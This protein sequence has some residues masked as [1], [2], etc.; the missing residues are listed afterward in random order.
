VLS[1]G[2]RLGVDEIARLTLGPALVVLSACRTGEGEIVPGEG[3][4]GLSWAFL[5]AGARGVVAS[6][7]SVEDQSTTELM[8]T[9]HR[10]L[11]RGSDPSSA[12]AAAQR[13]LAARQP[14][15]VFWA[16]FIVVAAPA[17]DAGRVLPDRPQ[18]S[19]REPQKP[20]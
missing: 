19:V 13:E 5:A 15:P 12:L 1:R 10:H 14:H 8:V 11:R 18:R 2:E 20:G 6:L 4:V 9:L 7:W 16:P 3:V 17:A